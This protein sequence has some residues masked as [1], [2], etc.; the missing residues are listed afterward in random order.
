MQEDEQQRRALE[1]AGRRASRG[2][3]LAL[4]LGAVAFLALVL[5]FLRMAGGI[6]G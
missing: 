3:V 1:A 2:L 6:W 4:M 5:W